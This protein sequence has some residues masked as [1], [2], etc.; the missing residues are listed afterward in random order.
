[1]HDFDPKSM[2][3]AASLTQLQI[4][5]LIGLNQSQ[6]SRFE[7]N[8]GKM[9]SKTRDKWCKICGDIYADDGI[10]INPS[11]RDALNA[12]IRLIEQY[13]EVVDLPEKP[14]TISKQFPSIDRFLHYVRLLA[15]KPRVGIVGKFDS[16]KSRLINT[17]IGQEVLPTGYQPETSVICLV[18]HN[19]DRPDWMKEDLE[20]M[21]QNVF[22]MKAEGRVENGCKEFD[23]DDLED[24]DHFQSFRCMSGGLDVLKDF[25]SHSGRRAID[26]VN[27]NMFAALVYVD[28]PLL[29]NCDIFDFPGYSNSEEDSQ[30]AEFA[31]EKKMLDI[32]VYTSTAIGFMGSVDFTFLNVHLAKLR[33][34]ESEGLTPLQNLFVVATRSS[35]VNI[36]ELAEIFEKS[37]ARTYD[38]LK[39]NLSEVLKDGV[40]HDAFIERFF[41]FDAEQI[42]CRKNFEGDLRELVEKRYPSLQRSRLNRAFAEAKGE[43]IAKLESHSDHI[44]GLLNDA[45][46][47]FKA[48]KVLE[49]SEPEK[50]A[51]RDS[52]AKQVRLK[53][54]RSKEETRTYIGTNL[55]K[56]CS[57][58]AIERLIR[59]KRYTQKEA[60]HEC[61][62]YLVNKLQTHLEKFLSTKAKE[63][64]NDIDRYHESFDHNDSPLSVDFLFDSRSAFIAGLA[65]VGTYGALSVWA[66]T[67]AAGSN[68]GAY[69][70]TTKA[71]SALSAMGISIGG[72][73]AVNAAIATIGGPVTIMAALAIGVAALVWAIFGKSWQE[74]LASRLAKSIFEEEIIQKLAERADEYWDSTRNAFDEG[75]DAA[76]KEYR[77]HMEMLRKQIKERDRQSLEEQ[78]KYTA[79]VRKLFEG[80]PWRHV[81]V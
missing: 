57:E 64:A 53:I 33:H 81:Q 49:K 40:S 62:I 11:A 69:I 59:D 63:L 70:L 55:K 14:E 31:K 2:R 27:Q 12:E 35:I 6:V 32:L 54:E 43:A 41:T 7:N 75:S 71:V 47:K 34:I 1:M 26:A 13:V 66:A 4:A 79:S 48:L 22:V 42:A 17:L 65:G 61:G 16:G 78:K 77:E 76:E 51:E 52:K 36:T 20:A 73:A 19:S 80:L 30:K 74:R 44:D 8:P 24:K 15:R 10:E 18:R 3:E 50:K 21:N 38:F 25:G 37:G 9:P 58:Q 29:M 28:A 5:K 46:S 68:L 45:D 56:K 72:T 39:D 23:F 67:V 60:Q